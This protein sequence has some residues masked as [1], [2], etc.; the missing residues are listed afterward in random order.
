M[1][2]VPRSATVTSRPDH[3]GS[4]RPSPP[5]DRVIAQLATRV[6][7]GHHHGGFRRTLW[8]DRLG[9]ISIGK[10]RGQLG[11]RAHRPRGRNGGQKT[12]LGRAARSQSNGRRPGRQ[13]G[14]HE[15]P[16]QKPAKS[17]ANSHTA[18]FAENT[19]PKGIKLPLGHG[20]WIGVSELGPQVHCLLTNSPTDNH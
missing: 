11:D 5:A 14:R 1:A 12:G 13:P 15:R 9:R 17:P 6:R 8:R 4:L 20:L 7:G 18:H 19:L 3:H 16:R 2:R 10:G